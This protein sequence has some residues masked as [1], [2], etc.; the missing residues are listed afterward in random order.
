MSSR[1]N[2][3]DAFDDSLLDGD[4]AVESEDD[5]SVE[6][7]EVEEDSAKEE[8]KESKKG[9]KESEKKT[10]TEEEE[11][12]E[13][14]DDEEEEEQDYKKLYEESESAR[15]KLASKLVQHDPFALIDEE[16]GEESEAKKKGKK[17]DEEEDEKVEEKKTKKKVEEVAEDDEQLFTEEEF[18]ELFD[19]RGKFNKRLGDKL[20]KREARLEERMLKKVVELQTDFVHRVTAGQRVVDNFF[21][22]NPD[23][24]KGELREI[25]EK[26][27]VGYKK[28]SPAMSGPEALKKAGAQ[29]RKQFRSQVKK[30]VGFSGGGTGATRVRK[31]NKPLTLQDELNEDVLHI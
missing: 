29:V 13:G 11:S 30:V 9:T 5:D 27:A 28:A 16:E 4:D 20:K 25:T 14:E 18:D 10:S 19:D 17:G 26:L 2:P 7:E 12:K 15:V 6:K 31:P 1:G 3:E 21:Q 24:A 22:E 8:G 23:L